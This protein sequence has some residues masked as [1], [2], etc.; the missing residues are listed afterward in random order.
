MNI[1]LAHAADVS[2]PSGGTER[3]SAF[4]SGFED[5][6]HD[7]TL[8]VPRPAE[9]FPERLSGVGISTVPIGRTGVLSQPVRGGAVVRRARRLAAERN[10]VLQIEHSPLA[11]LGATLGCQ[12]F[13][14][15]MHDLAFPSPVY[16]DLPMGWLAQRFVKTMEGKGLRNAAEI[17]VVSEEMR[18]LVTDTWDVDP[19]RLTTI[20]NGYL[21]DVRESFADTQ[22][23]PGRVVFLGSLHPKLSVEPFERICRLPEVSELVVVGDG[24]KRSE[25]ESIDRDELALTG[26][27]PDAEA[28][29]LVA[30]AAVAIN[31]Q[32]VSR[33][34]RA[35]SPVKLYYYTALGVPMV[36]TEGPDVVHYLG[37]RGAAAVVPDGGDFADAVRRVLSD[38][39][40]RASMRDELREL[41]S[42]FTWETRVSRLLDLYER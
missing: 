4:A 3:V 11:G 2:R 34:Q 25:L 35:S 5:A 8:V 6:G 18:R 16:G 32:R 20:P 40:R 23:V 19:D 17:V 15:D 28:Y 26:F 42:E 27:L 10:A 22:T 21:A 24:A 39:A 13:V 12:G 7:V 14:L 30:S 41:A 9:S 31:P 38:D 29:E 33:L 36:L 37:D 1:V